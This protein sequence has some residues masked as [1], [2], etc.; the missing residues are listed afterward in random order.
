MIER[1]E[2]IQDIIEK[3]PSKFG[4]VVTAFILLLFALIITLAFVVKYPD[5]VTGNI[6]IRRGTLPIRLT[7]KTSGNIYLLKQI[8]TSSLKIKK[9]DY[10]AYFDNPTNVNNIYHLKT[11]LNKYQG[12]ADLK[13]LRDSL[14][15]SKLKYGELTTKVSQVES[16]VEKILTFN[17]LNVYVEQS[18][19]IKS[20]V[21]EQG[22]LITAIDEQILIH[23]DNLVV[24]KQMFERDSLMYG[25]ELIS[26]LEYEKSR[27]N[28][29]SNKESIYAL[30]KE[31]FT[32]SQKYKDLTS[33]G[34]Q[35]SVAKSDKF[36]DLDIAFNS[37]LNDLTE[38]IKDW[39]QK[40]VIVCPASG[41]LETL[42]YIENGE[43][44]KSGEE[45]FSLTPDYKKSVDGIIQTLGDGF[46]KIKKGQNVIIKM[47]D[48][49]YR[50]FGV[51]RG[52]VRSIARSPKVVNDAK[53]QEI[54]TY[55]VTVVFPKKF[56]SSSKRMLDIKSGAR[57]SADII[58]NEQRLI[59]RIFNT[60]KFSLNK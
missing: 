6:L 19:G 14:N 8:Q 26:R 24:A 3:M 30:R 22:N 33:Q 36:Q 35:L 4:R 18:A 17:L 43:F 23:Q 15:S 32:L 38:S 37:A 57:G 40:Y 47:E 44:V 51:L 46:G 7:T 56:E 29:L 5:V 11:I 54:N 42:K 59:E 1:A 21:L 55:L 16:T 41:N 49:P 58:T 52:V 31:R 28:Y 60:V 10:L 50:E 34:K 12:N 27:S 20:S 45:L 9:G 53:S 2:E 13:G 48:F 25:K 39:E